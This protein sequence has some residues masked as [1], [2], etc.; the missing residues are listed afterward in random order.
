MTF[1][2]D[3]YARTKR[4]ASSSSESD[5]SSSESDVS[6]SESDVSSSESDVITTASDDITTERSDDIT[7]ERSDDIT[8]ERSD[9]ITTERGDDITTESDDITTESDSTT[10]VDECSLIRDFFETD[11]TELPL[12]INFLF[13]Y[14][15]MIETTQNFFDLLTS[16][17]V[18]LTNISQAVEAASSQIMIPPVFDDD[19]NVAATDALNALVTDFEALANDP[20]G[21]TLTP[22]QGAKSF[23]FFDFVLPFTVVFSQECNLLSVNIIE[24]V[25]A[26]ANA[27]VDDSRL[28]NFLSDAIDIDLFLITRL[29]AGTSLLVNGTPDELVPAAAQAFLDDFLFIVNFCGFSPLSNTTLQQLND[30]FLVGLVEVALM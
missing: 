24:Q 28:E 14:R 18:L 25:V 27:T 22:T 7:T 4:D 12:D 20:C 5:V 10:P 16:A 8:T 17:P 11:I 15:L 3:L 2:Q 30:Y 21:V 6:S 26:A 1:M 19:A 29:F 23:S 13:N 9:D